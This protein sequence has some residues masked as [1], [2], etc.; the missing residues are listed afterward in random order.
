MFVC[1]CFP[2]QLYSDS[3]VKLSDRCPN[4]VTQTT[5][6]PKNEISV[7]WLAP[8]AGAG[9]IAF[10]A[11]LV[12]RKD[13]WYMDDTSLVKVICEE[14]GDNHDEQPEIMEKCC[15]CDEAKYEVTFEGLWSK[16]THPKDFPTNPFNTHF[17]DIIGAS[18]SSDF[19][20]WEYG[21]YASEG[22]RQVAESGITKKLESELKAESSKIRTIIKARGIWYP[23]LNGKTFAVFRVDNKHHLMSLLSV[24]VPSPDW[25]VGVSSLELCLKNCSWVGEKVMNL[26]LWDAGIDSG[27]TY[28]S[29]NS[30][31]IPQERIRRITS[32]SPNLPESPFFDPSG[33]KMKPMARLTV[34]RQRIYEKACGDDEVRFGVS[35][36]EDSDASRYDCMVT[37][38]TV[39]GPC[40]QE[41][42]EGVRVR[43]RN[44]VNAQRA[45]EAGCKMKLIEKEDCGA[46]CVNNISCETTTWSEWSPCSASCGRGTRTRNRI[47]MHR[48]AKSVCTNVELVQR[49]SCIAPVQE[50]P[51]GGQHG[52]GG[53]V[54]RI[55]A[56]CSVT[57]WSEWSPC[58]EQCGKGVRIRTR[59]YINPHESKKVCN[60]QLIQ[61]MDCYG[62]N[63]QTDQPDNRSKMLFTCNILPC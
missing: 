45:K 29:P 14:E 28:L 21:G 15:A 16:Y 13:L 22:V 42:G 51:G 50:C 9:C 20:I 49:E 6:V 41:C 36:F 61:P 35:E 52:G 46:K 59:I 4:A 3:L 18:H 48:M 56:K 47:F 27:V 60:V 62:E 1:L 34:S 55:D 57:N 54:E 37:E 2:F 25:I 26:Y 8:P 5:P 11:T 10:K 58:T 30:P 43:T 44:Y 53:E 40:S 38:W 31:T 23:N 17:S 33:T 39:F 32:T 7:M 63:C 19:R 24:L 12:E